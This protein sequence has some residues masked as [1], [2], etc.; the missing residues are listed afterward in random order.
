MSPNISHL[1]F[2]GCYLFGISIVIYSVQETFQIAQSELVYSVMCNSFRWCLILGYS[3]IFGTVLAKVW[4]VY[5]LFNH[6]RNKS[7][8]CLVSDNALTIF[9]ILLLLV[10]MCICTTWDFL[11][12]FIR[13]TKIESTKQIGK[14]P[15][16]LIRSK[17]NCRHFSWWIAVVSAYKGII[18]LLL[19]VFS[20]LNRKIRRQ[21]FQHTKKINILIYS[22]T[23]MGGVCFPIYFLLLSYNIHISF[24]ILCFMLSVSI[25]MSCLTLS[26]SPLVQVMRI[27]I[28]LA[29]DSR[30][31]RS[32]I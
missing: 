23:M 28:G 22:L 15:S 27:K 26:L 4:R 10:D 18:A 13:E 32:M 2:A 19:V 30:N 8:G 6:F 24:I 7:P 1:I 5:R 29:K 11:D 9:V 21:N 16:L 14:I 17:C 20:I 31:Q 3:L 25:L 12:P